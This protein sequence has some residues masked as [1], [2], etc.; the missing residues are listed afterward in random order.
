MTD[1]ERRVPSY[2]TAAAKRESER[3]PLEQF[4]VNNEPADVSEAEA[5]T[6]ELQAVLDAAAAS[7]PQPAQEGWKPSR[8]LERELAA[9]L[10]D[11]DSYREE[12]DI[13]L[14]AANAIRADRDLHFEMRFK[15]EAALAK[16]ERELSASEE[17]RR[18][19]RSEAE[20]LRKE[21]DAL[22]I[23]LAD[24]NLERERQQTRAETAEREAAKARQKAI[25]D[26]EAECERLAARAGSQGR[27][28]A[29]QYYQQWQS[30]IRAL[31]T[32]SSPSSGQAHTD[33][34]MRHFDRTCPACVASAEDSSVIEVSRNP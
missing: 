23:R 8:Q 22:V 31:T 20:E 13:A 27:M 32:A 25:K 6:R 12:S 33:H 7:A 21:R 28:A 3:T 18:K 19:A 24:F 14:D 17:A 11:R 34:P 30:A 4:V 26:L 1:L 9:A 29:R 5:F 10:S 15:A 16:L 2:F